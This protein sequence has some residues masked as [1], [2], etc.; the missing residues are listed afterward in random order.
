[1][2]FSAKLF[3][4]S[5]FLFTLAF[6]ICG[7]ILISQHFQS[8]VERELDREIAEHQSLKFLLQSQ[9]ITSKLEG[10]NL[11]VRGSHLR[12]RKGFA[13]FRPPV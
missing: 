5:M 3:L 10:K 12:L 2:R 1:M 4:S 6:S 9:L 8:T 13:K 11:Y 7:T